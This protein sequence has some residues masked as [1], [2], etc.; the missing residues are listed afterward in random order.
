M[1][2]LKVNKEILPR[3]AWLFVFLLAIVGC[4]NYLDRIMITTMR[5]SIIDSIPMSETEFGLLT[6]VFLWVYGFLSPFGGYLADKFSRSKVIIFSLFIWSLVTYL[7]SLCTSYEELLVTRALMGVSEACY[8]PAA[9][10]FITDYHQ[11]KTRSLAVGIHMSGI[12]LGQSLGFVGGWMAETHSWSFAFEFFGV[13]G[14]IYAFILGLIIKDSPQTTTHQEQGSRDKVYF[15]S[16]I[17][18][19]FSR[20]GFRL[21]LVFWSLFGISG[22]LIIGWLP[23][24]YQEKFNF[25]QSTAGF[26]ATAFLYSA[27][28]VGVIFG[29]F[30]ADKWAK[31]NPRSRILLPAI[32]L[33]IGAP[34]IYFASTS[35]LLI[36]AVVGFMIYSFTRAFT[37]SNMMPILCMVSNVKHRA[38]GYGLLNFFS[39]LIGGI[40]LYAGGIL[41]DM[42]ISLS[43]I[44]IL[45]SLAMIV[46]G[47]TLFF[48]KKEE[49]IGENN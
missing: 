14:I 3:K 32:G 17:K 8:I 36:V 12:I 16:A 10:A 15:W 2:Q 9:L 34:A 21:A 1:D 35:Q 44:F 13:F 41:R 27:S 37:D 38:T 31:V 11:N 23:T 18:D 6:A 39:C 19:L 46:G 48:I 20:Q 25:S 26:Y 43:I 45:A 7:T 29:G 4:L 49:D 30:L 33:L 24:F 22:W 47:F 42:N 5:S 40:G 28:F